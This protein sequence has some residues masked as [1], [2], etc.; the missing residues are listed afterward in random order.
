MQSCSHPYSSHDL[1]SVSGC[2]V[3]LVLLLI[4][5]HCV[6]IAGA[7]ALTYALAISTKTNRHEYT[8]ESVYSDPQNHILLIFNVYKA[9]FAQSVRGTHHSTHTI[10]LWF[11]FIVSPLS[12]RTSTLM[13]VMNLTIDQSKCLM[14]WWKLVLCQC[15]WLVPIESSGMGKCIMQCVLRARRVQT[16]GEWVC[17]E[18]WISAC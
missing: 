10:W 18:G 6:L 11:S 17:T 8:L 9:G 4:C 7:W 13:T 1:H 12:C 15:V 3:R 2:T 5:V 14:A 16:E